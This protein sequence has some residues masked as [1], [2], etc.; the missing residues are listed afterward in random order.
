MEIEKAATANNMA[1]AAEHMKLMM[2]TCGQCHT[3][4][5]DKAADGTYIIK[6]Q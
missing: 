5:R 2:G 1:S 4:Y 6:K 3:K